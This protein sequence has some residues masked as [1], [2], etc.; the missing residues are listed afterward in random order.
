MAEATR[1]ER[2][3][4]AVIDAGS[5]TIT[6]VAADAMR[7]YSMEELLERWNGLNNVTLTISCGIPLPLDG[8]DIG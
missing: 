7:T 8:R 2:F 5:M 4:G 3:T 1:S 6:E